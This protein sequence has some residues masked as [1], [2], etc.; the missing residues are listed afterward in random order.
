VLFSKRAHQLIELRA[1]GNTG[2]NTPEQLL[3]A[4]RLLAMSRLLS[5]CTGDAVADILV[6]E[7]I[8][9]TVC[10]IMPTLPIMMMPTQLIV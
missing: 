9:S 6:V 7:A 1:R 10:F 8:L 3:A 4:D 5:Q 2:S